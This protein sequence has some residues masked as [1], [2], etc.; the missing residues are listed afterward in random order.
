MVG[1]VSWADV[2]SAL[3]RVE[4]FDK[5]IA[6]LL[7]AYILSLRGATDDDEVLGDEVTASA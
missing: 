4:Q 3:E 2:L 7:R 6:N 5:D 1:R